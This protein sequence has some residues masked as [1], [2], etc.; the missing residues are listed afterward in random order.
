MECVGRWCGA[1]YVLVAFRAAEFENFCIVADEC[2]TLGGIARLRAE[3]TRLDSH[4]GGGLEC[5]VVVVED[6]EEY[7]YCVAGRRQKRILLACR[8]SPELF[9]MPRFSRDGKFRSTFVTTVNA[10]FEQTTVHHIN[11][12]QVRLRHGHRSCRGRWSRRSCLLRTLSHHHHHHHRQLA[13]SNPSTNTVDCNSQGR[14]GLVALRRARGGTSA[15]G[16]AYYKGGFEK[17]MNRRE[18]ALIL[19]TS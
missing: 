10:A 19:E 15:L 14:A 5:S 7:L 4:R 3:I 12:S 18:A 6:V 16:K 1:T 13:A 11:R 2:D 9:V 17:Q 8:G